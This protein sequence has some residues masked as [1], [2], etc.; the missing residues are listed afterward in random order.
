MPEDSVD[1]SVDEESIEIVPPHVVELV[2]RAQIDLQI[3]TAKKYPR[4][5]A[6]VK[7]RMIT[8]ATM[9]EETAEGCFYSLERGRNPDNTKKYIH[10]PSVRLAEIAINCYGNTRSAAR[11]IDNDGQIITSQGV[12]HDLENNNLISM[13]VQ[14]RITDKHGKTFTQDMQVVTGN[15]ANAIS[16][17]NAVLKVIP[18]MLVKPAY[19]AA[20]EVA[21]GNA[22]TLSAKREKF[23]ARFKAMGVSEDRVLAK[24]DKS[25]I[26]NVDLAD[27]ETMIGLGTAIKE[28][29]ATVEETFP[30]TEGS[31]ESARAEVD[32]KVSDLRAAG[33]IVKNVEDLTKEKGHH[34]ATESKG[35]SGNGNAGA[36]SEPSASNEAPTTEASGKP[37]PVAP[38][39]P[40]HVKDIKAYADRLG[41]EAVESIAY[42]HG[43]KDG[44]DITAELL[45]K[46]QPAMERAVAAKRKA[47]EKQNGGEKKPLTNLKGQGSIDLK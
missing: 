11:V 1:Q 44:Q 4:D 33:T 21:V 46:M 31:K 6:K 30:T 24:L 40:Q 42:E 8:F 7:K 22:T 38:E 34:H 43:W 47:E 5:L 29:D 19:D 17:R 9:D 10:G 2:E 12:C 39:I 35:E 3:S 25:S 26:E 20:R 18:G 28:G 16:W 32:K 41:M 27:I 14:R 45:V 13:A 36:S 15:A 37:A 23:F